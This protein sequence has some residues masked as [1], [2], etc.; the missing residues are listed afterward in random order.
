MV[1]VSKKLSEF[2]RPSEHSTFSPSSMDRFIM[3]PASLR[4]CKDVPQEEEQDYSK[5]GT[6]AHTVAETFFYSTMLDIPMPND[7]INEMN[8]WPKS[9]NDM[10]IGASFYANEVRTW[11]AHPEIG[12]VL[13]Y[14]LERGVPIV[15]EESCFGTGDCIIVGTKGAA[16][17]DYK[18]GRKRVHA[19]SMQLRAYAAGV[20]KHLSDVP[21]DYR[22]FTVIVQPRVDLAASVHCYMKEEIES[23]FSSITDMIRRSKN[24]S[25]L[26]IRG[27]KKHCFWC[28]A[29]RTKDP[30]FK[31]PAIKQELDTISAEDF[32]GYLIGSSGEVESIGPNAR[33][34]ES[35][36]KLIAFAPIIKQAAEKAQQE[37]EFRLERGEVIEGVKL[38]DVEGKRY[39][40]YDDQRMS[41]MLED[42]FDK[43]KDSTM[44]VIP[45]TVKLKTIGEIEKVIG[46]DK[47]EDFTT[48]PVKKEIVLEDAETLKL[49]KQFLDYE[50][51]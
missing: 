19:D 10:A 2:V 13:W 7:L 20:L 4:I 48:R 50:D 28:P 37:L 11:L 49:R 24:P 43:L 21:E 51:I 44:T 5:E 33:R 46:K 26:P 31:C 47:L 27:D 12:E 35:L 30:A 8:L 42:A 41:K 14:G 9:M 38:A 17:I 39:W 16:V 36:K 29:S 25:E 22:I 23:F 3:C 45:A 18:F 15:P 40:R 6:L 32:R 1:T 34:D